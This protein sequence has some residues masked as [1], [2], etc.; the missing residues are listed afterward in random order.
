MPRASIKL[1]LIP[2]LLV[3]GTALLAG[4][5]DSDELPPGAV[6]KVGDTVITQEKFD[7]W[8][9]T[10]VKGQ[11]GGAKAVVPDPPEFTKCVAGKKDQPTPEG[12]PEPSAGDLK[13]QCKTEYDELKRSVM[14]FLIQSEWVLQEAEQQKV[15]VKDAEVAKSFEDQKK[16]AFPKEA[17]YQKFLAS[18]GMTEKD[19][20]F[21]VRLQFLR[22][23]LTKKV[24]EKST[25][26]SDQQ[27]EAYYDKNKK[28]FAQP[29]RRDLLLVVTKTKPKA[30]EAKKALNRGQPWKKVASKYSIDEATKAQGGKFPGVAQGQ[31]EPQLDK[32]TFGAD[33][34][35]L[36]GPVKTQFGWY[37]V[38]VDKIIPASQ[39]SLE[40]STDTIKNLLRSQGQQKALDRFV[41]DFRQEYKDITECDKEYRVAECKNAPKEKK[42]AAPGAPSA[43]GQGQAPPPPQQQPPPTPPESE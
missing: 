27:I 19:I 18:S 31:Q 37:V 29:E 23:E 24:S 11:A 1:P 43:P 26:V 41:K 7:K 28:Q 4:C 20:L 33:K 35:E 17:D 6:A 25:K 36:V 9:T 22:D 32:L 38:E 30:E 3:L 13:K 2:V 5:G 8:M 10:A 16:Q 34:G 12:Q 39:Q 42:G 15:T 21:R 40:E 14:Q